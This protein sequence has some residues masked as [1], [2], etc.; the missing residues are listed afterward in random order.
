M[1]RI[2]CYS[3]AKLSAAMINCSL[4]SVEIFYVCSLIFF[5]LCI[6]LCQCASSSFIFFVYLLCLVFFINLLHRKNLLHLTPLPRFTG[7]GSSMGVFHLS[8]DRPSAG[9]ETCTPARSRK[10]KTASKTAQ[11]NQAEARFYY[12]LL[13]LLR[14]RVCHQAGVDILMDIF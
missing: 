4:C 12:L 2:E 9:R 14:Q 6:F 5:E 7:T 11:L 1:S 8:S 10:E 13:M 3:S